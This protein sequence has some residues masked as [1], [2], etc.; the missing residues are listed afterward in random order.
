MYQCHIYVFPL[1]TMSLGWYAGTIAQMS[2]RMVR[3]VA[4]TGSATSNIT[5]RPPFPYRG[6]SMKIKTLAVA[7]GI[8]A[9][10][11]LGGSASGGFTGI[12]TTSKPNEFGLFVVNVYAEFDRP[13]ADFV[14][15]VGGT[16]LNPLTIEVIGGTFYQHPFG[17]DRAP[18]GVVDA[19]PSLA[20]DTF[21]TIGVKCVGDPPCQQIDRMFFTPGWPGFG[22]A[23]LRLTNDAWALTPGSPA[24][25]PFNP[26]YFAGDGRVLIGQFSTLDGTAIQG[27]M[28]QHITSNGQA[29]SQ[30]VVSFFVPGPGALW[31]LGAM[32]L[33]GRRRRR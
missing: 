11:I 18:T 22:P 5:V 16:A 21:V 1:R 27:T 19:F 23:A 17:D 4:A 10:L 15:G 8:S 29:G 24:S 28:R 32:G 14:L 26:D 31:L 9:P 20:Y 6:C 7:A 30:A 12:S 2:G 33:L 25:D 13:G 3:L